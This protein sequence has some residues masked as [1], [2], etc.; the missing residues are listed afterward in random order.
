VSE[1]LYRVAQEA[2]HNVARHARATRVDVLL[3]C[4]PEEATLVLRDNG[5]G[6]DTQQARR[7][8]GLGSMQDRMMSIGGR[9]TIASAI[10]GGTTVRAQVAL[11]HPVSLQAEASTP[12]KDQPNPTIENWAWLGQRLVIPVGQT[13]PWLP[14]DQAHLRRP[15]V[16]TSMGPLVARYHAGPLG[17]DRQYHLETASGAGERVRVHLR[18]A[19]YHWRDGE[20]VWVLKQLRSPSGTYRAVLMR[21]RQPLAALQS[22]GRLLNRWTEIIYDDRGYRLAVDRDR[23]GASQPGRYV[24]ADQR[25][26]PLLRIEEG[27]PTIVRLC[28]TLA[29]PLLIIVLMQTISQ[30]PVEIAQKE[31]QE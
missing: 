10:G 15:L 1:S 28:R 16:E 17:F 26:E 20:A 5:A 8:L 18:H 23:S 2:L 9:L 11:T 29:L 14:A 4:L 19:N 12:A 7:G 30:Q 25:G 3:R 13:W 31:S 27:A 6:F 22:Q 21:N 24:L